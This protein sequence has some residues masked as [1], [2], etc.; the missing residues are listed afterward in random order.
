M[1]THLE[2]I[3]RHRFIRVARTNNRFHSSETGIKHGNIRVRRDLRLIRRCHPS[4]V[5]IIP[6]NTLSINVRNI[7]RDGD[8]K[9]THFKNKMH[10]R[11]TKKAW[12]LISST[13]FSEP[14]LSFGSFLRRP[15]IKW[16]ASVEKEG[17]N[18]TWL[19]RIFSAVAFLSPSWLNGG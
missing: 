16:M 7:I 10:T 6:I 1:W 13:S 4:I 3:R 17:G 19:L 8:N 11:R 18:R 2:E 9:I 14:I 5:D 12:L 15:R